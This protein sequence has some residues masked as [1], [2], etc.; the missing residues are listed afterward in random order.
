MIITATLPTAG[1]QNGHNY[2]GEKRLCAAYSV[3]AIS[4][5]SG[6]LEEPITVRIWCD[7]SKSPSNNYASIWIHNA[8]FHSAGHGRANGWGYHRPSAALDAAIKSAGIV[9]SSPIDGVG[10]GAMQSAMAAI[11]EALGYSHFMV[12]SHG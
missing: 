3:V 8:S 9:L 4:P 1:K 11:A 6:D 7:W 2:S 12:T 10:D 5:L